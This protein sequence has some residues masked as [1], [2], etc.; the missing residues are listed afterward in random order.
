MFDF[1]MN[2]QLKSNFGGCPFIKISAEVSREEKKVFQLV[3]SHKD[4]FKSYIKD[5]VLQVEPKQTLL[6]PDMIVETLYL[7]MEG[8]SATVNIY[9]DK[10]ALTDAKKIAE[11]L[12]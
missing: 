6:D 5:L 10:K 3:S 7:L 12:I 9:K 4:R 8:A 11:K 2:R 1:R